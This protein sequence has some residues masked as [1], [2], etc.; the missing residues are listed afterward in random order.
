MEE[1]PRDQLLLR[2]E[3]LIL[4]NGL[5]DLEMV[6]AHN[7]G[8]MVQDTKASGKA[9]KLMAKASLSMRMVTSTKASG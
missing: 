8:L 3:Q 5:M 4:V 7:F 1:S 9:I 2:T 6:L